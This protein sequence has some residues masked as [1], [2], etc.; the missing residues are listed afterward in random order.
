MDLLNWRTV[1]TLFFKQDLGETY[2][3]KWYDAVQK[4]FTIEMDDKYLKHNSY[5]EF[6]TSTTEGAKVRLIP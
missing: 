3:V 1:A 4:T 5:P 6:W 2:G